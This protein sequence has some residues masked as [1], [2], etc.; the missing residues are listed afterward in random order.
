MQRD[1]PPTFG[2]ILRQYRQ[3]AH[4]SQEELSE[5]AG[6]SKRAISDLERGVNRTPRHA[7]L[8]LLADALQLP[9]PE[10]LRFE[11]AAWP[12][13]SPAPQSEGEPPVGYIPAPLTSFIGREAEVDSALRLLRRPGVRLVSFLGTGG[14]GKTRLALQVAAR[15]GG[16]FPDGC[17]FVDLSPLTDPTDVVSTIAGVLGV[18]EQGT[19]PLLATLKQ[20][21]RSKT[22]LLVL[23]NFEQVGASA[24]QVEALLQAAPHLTVLA[25]SRVPLGIYGERPFPVP[26]MALP[27]L[28]A[29]PGA[30]QLAEC[31]AVL[32]FVE[33]TQEILPDFVLTTEN[34][35]AVAEICVRLD[36]LPLAIEL[37]AARV[38]VF[39]PPVLLARLTARL[40]ARLD[41]LASG[42]STRAERQQT[43]RATIDWSYNLLTSAEQ[44]LFRRMAVFQG[45]AGLEALQAVYGSIDGSGVRGSV[46][47]RDTD[48]DAYALATQVLEHAEAL[49]RKNL[50]QQ[51]PYN[52]GEGSVR[53]TMLETIHEYGLETLVP[54]REAR[55]TRQAHAEYYLALA[56]GVEGELTGPQQL[57]WFGRLEQE[58]DNLRAALSWLLEQDSDA[59][60]Q[61]NEMALRL[62]GALSRFWGTR[63]YVSEGR[64]WLERA[65][66]GSP[67]VRS[68]ARAK[69]LVG[70][71]RLATLQDDFAQAEALC[72]E[73]F[74][75]YQELGNRSGSAASLSRWGY[76]AMMR[77]N[78]SQARAR[79]EEALAL[80]RELDDRVGSVFVLSVLGSLLRYQ[81][82]YARARALLEEALALSQVAG[83]IQGHALSLLILGTLLLFAGDLT[84]AQARLEESLAVSRK[85]GYKRNIALSTYIL[86]IVTYQQGDLARARSLYE[87]S[88][89]LLKEVGERG[90]VASVIGS[91]GR[92]ALTQGDY[93]AARALLEESLQL[94]V[95]LDEK[96]ETTE[97]LEGLAAVMAAQGEA[98]WAARCMSAAQALREAIGAHLPPVFQPM[99]DSTIASVRKQLGERVFAAAW[100]EGRTMSPEQILARRKL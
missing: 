15:L 86:G 19:Q 31:E 66:T 16:D 88:L 29:L 73:G 37:A 76:S 97:G 6:L 93:V 94:S 91:Q 52:D 46:G 28:K 63:G 18:K 90:R 7:T 72:A 60:E 75:L 65:L 30:R 45:G 71:G 43:L 68:A 38:P 69:A 27:D 59:D 39:S 53:F 79:L 80:Y 34:A 57:G 42:P 24:A 50:V 83:D 8:A 47:M 67:G 2:E 21:L 78:Y 4:L 40:G 35:E 54:G 17:W 82:E 77:S 96:W 99:H 36:G 62:C 84:Q 22:M 32:L 41:A 61:S 26:P 58:H 14:S 74:A 13:A 25:T 10:R 20:A 1:S 92:L 70:A 48:A 95:E 5:R 64:R 51:R 49:A 89:V 85:L 55:A 98:G 12:T 9:P 100:A 56:E 81:G 11:A 23:D 44:A 33:R 3:A 87:E